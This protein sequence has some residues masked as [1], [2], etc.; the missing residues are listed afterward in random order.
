MKR[1]LVSLLCALYAG[2]LLGFLFWAG[3]CTFT[4]GVDLCGPACMITFI[5]HVG[6]IMIYM[7]PAW[8]EK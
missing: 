1:L 6:G 2:V 5:S 7:C 8:E 4:R 3:G